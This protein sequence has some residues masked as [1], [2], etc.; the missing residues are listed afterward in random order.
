MDGATVKYKAPHVTSSGNAQIFTVENSATGIKE[1][2]F[3]SASEVSTHT[4]QYY[5]I[6]YVDGSKVKVVDPNGYAPSFKQDGTPLYD[7]N[8]IYLN[9]QGNQVIFNVATNVWIKK[10]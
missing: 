4:G 3:S 10:K 7:K 5:K 1:V 8:T 6:T 9:P 2:Q